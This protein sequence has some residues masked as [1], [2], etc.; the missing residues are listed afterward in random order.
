MDKKYYAGLDIGGTKCACII[1]FDDGEKLEIVFREAIPTDKTVS[2]F[3]MLER[4][5]AILAPLLKEYPI[6][7]IGISCGGPLDSVHGI[8]QSPPNLP[9]WDDIHICEYFEKLHGLPVKLQN[10]ANACGLAEWMFGAGKGTK[11]MV[12]CTMGT[13]FG[14]GLI[15]DGKLYAGTNDNAGEIGHIRL[16]DEGPIGYGKRGSVE[17]YCSGGGI[18]QVGRSAAMEL[19]QTGR[20]C[21]FCA[22]MAELD[23]ITAKSIGIAAQNGDETA[24]EVYKYVGRM[25][26][27]AMSVVIDLLNP[28]M[29]VIGSVFVRSEQLLR[30]EM[31]KVIN[32]E[33][34]APA[35]AACRVVPAELGE[36]L[37]DIAAIS[38]AAMK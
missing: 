14:A 32:S 7:S 37:G 11:N 15:L 26:G 35:A 30:D 20:P 6:C 21:A 31:Q 19:L 16:T 29:I 12:F 8:I 23:S 9:G 10:D 18:A 25:L 17:G 34:L 33:C 27:K 38:V 5:D 13:G 24:I 4:L 1:G 22:S 2:A 28:E 36:A 3:V